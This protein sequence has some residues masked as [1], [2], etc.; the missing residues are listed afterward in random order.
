M[1]YYPEVR[2]GADFSIHEMNQLT[3]RRRWLPPFAVCLT[4]VEVRVYILS[5]DSEI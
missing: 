5:S 3:Q 2:F 4:H 1:V